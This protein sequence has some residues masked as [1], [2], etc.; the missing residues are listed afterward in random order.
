[1]FHVGLEEKK[2]IFMAFMYTETA[3]RY[4]V[5]QFKAIFN[6]ASLLPLVFDV[7]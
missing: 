2:N 3:T 4:C 5:T 7:C 6:S 1:M